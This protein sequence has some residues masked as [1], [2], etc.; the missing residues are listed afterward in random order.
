MVL[1]P[2]PLSDADSELVIQL[3]VLSRKGKQRATLADQDEYSY[4]PPAIHND[5][6][7]T[8]PISLV[9]APV[10]AL[11]PQKPVFSRAY[12]SGL[13]R[14]VTNTLFSPPQRSFVL[15]SRTHLP[16]ATSPPTPLLEAGSS[17]L[18]LPVLTYTDT[19]PVFS[20]SQMTG[21]LTIDMRALAILAGNDPDEPKDVAD[22][23]LLVAAAMAYLDFLGDRE[24]SHL[25]PTSHAQLPQGYLAAANG[26]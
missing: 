24:V 18:G 23:G 8:I 1:A 26:G 25:L 22:V 12:A 17:A 11:I 19:T 14:I 2:N 20:V 15:L 10:P 4:P 5:P 21:S 7:F 9:F 3:P 16:S 13:V 6:P